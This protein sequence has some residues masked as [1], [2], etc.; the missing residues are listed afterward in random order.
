[1]RV[2]YYIIENFLKLL[3]N[4]KLQYNYGTWCNL[5]TI[6]IGIFRILWVDRIVVFHP[7]TFKISRFSSWKP[8]KKFRICGLLRLSLWSCWYLNCHRSLFLKASKRWRFLGRGN[9]LFRCDVNWTIRLF[10]FQW[11]HRTCYHFHHHFLYGLINVTSQNIK[12]LKPWK[13]E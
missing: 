2:D 3:L 8:G 9:N 11:F 13:S 6:V 12:F 10:P 1:M 7:S 5:F 4:A